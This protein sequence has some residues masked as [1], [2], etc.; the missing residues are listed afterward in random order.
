MPGKNRIW[1]FDFLKVFTAAMLVSFATQFQAT[2]FPLYVQ[3][4]GGNLAI[5][6]LMTSIYMGTSALSKPFAG[7][8]VNNKPRKIPCLTFGI[9]FACIMSSY[10]FIS[11][12]P[13][14]MVIRAC[15]APCYSI[16]STAYTTMATDM[17]PNTRMV[18]GIGYFNFSQTISAAFGSTIALFIINNL[19]YKSLFLSCTGCVFLAVLIILVTKYEDPILAKKTEL[20]PNQQNPKKISFRDKLKN[21][22]SPTM[23][24]STLTLFFILIGSS[25][26]VTY[27]PTWGKTVGIANIGMFFT[28]QAI[29]LAVSRLFVGK[30]NKYIG[31]RKSIVIGVI[32]IE[33]CLVGI[34]FCTSLSMLCML[35]LLLGLG[36]GII[37]PTIHAIMVML[38]SH[39]ERGM[40]NAVFQMANDAGICICSLVLGLLAQT[41]GLHDVFT[42][43]SVFPLIGI[44]VYITKLRNQIIENNL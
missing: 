10:G 6:G 14:I 23:L 44:V 22:I 42:Y 25:G 41:F 12:I 8:L 11:T 15:S 21:T 29:T 26:V 24:P 1:S 16:C 28:C 32:C 43:A 39:E 4:L 5:A 3:Y 19:G 7:S 36:S 30:I 37:V 17:I 13:L 20:S 31:S 34:R 9:I 38:C 40:A 18:E 35:S 2:T 33:I 27:L